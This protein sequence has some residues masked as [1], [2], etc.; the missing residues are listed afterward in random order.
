MARVDSSHF[1][2]YKTSHTKRNIKPLM[3]AILWCVPPL[4]HGGDYV[5]C[6]LDKL[7][8]TQNDAVAI[9]ISQVCFDEYPGGYPAVEQG[10]GMGWLAP[11]DSG[12]ICT[13]KKAADT[14]S[15]R[16]ATMIGRACR[17]LFDRPI[18]TIDTKPWEEA[19]QLIERKEALAKE[20]LSPPQKIP[21]KNLVEQHYQAIYA[22]HP[23]ADQIAN[24]HAFQSWTI[25]TLNETTL[26]KG[27]TQEIIRLFR[28]YKAHLLA[29]KAPQ[30]RQ[31]DKQAE[32]K[33]SYKAVMTDQ[34]YKDCGIN[35]PK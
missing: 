14:H 2:K 33:C 35:P 20:A 25:K 3:W 4:A 12:A 23:D 18:A 7:P 19:Y 27:S 16:A 11:Y 9:A 24:S 28:E 34:D 26:R 1:K 8:G 22:A 21:P 13:M 32:N 29:N 5:N 6:L 30:K 31:T 15:S 17:H 10:S